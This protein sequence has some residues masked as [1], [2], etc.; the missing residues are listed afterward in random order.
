MTVK[1]EV[2]SLSPRTG[3]PTDNPKP[4]KITVRIDEESKSILENYCEKENVSRMEA[5]R[6]GIKKLESEKK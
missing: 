5:I 6:R 1:S 3:R 2:I 4:Y